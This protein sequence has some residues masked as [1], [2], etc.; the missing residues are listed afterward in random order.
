M[1][2]DVSTSEL[3]TSAG[4]LIKEFVCPLSKKWQELESTENQF[5]RNCEGCKKQVID[6]SQL[7]KDLVFNLFNTRNDICGYINIT[8]TSENI[9]FKNIDRLDNAYIEIVG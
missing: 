1:I 4:N 5:V 6:I 9:V 3:R 8:D 2:F 7:S